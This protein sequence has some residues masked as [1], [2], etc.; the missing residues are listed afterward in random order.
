MDLFTDLWRL[1]QIE[2]KD[3]SLAGSD[4]VFDF[5]QKYA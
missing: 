5:I 1:H 3:I 2:D 4:D